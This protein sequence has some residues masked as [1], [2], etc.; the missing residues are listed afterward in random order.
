MG[1]SAHNPR[2]TVIVLA[3]ATTLALAGC[4]GGD[5]SEPT[6]TVGTQET[7]CE[8]VAPAAPKRVNLR[9]TKTR[10]ESGRDI[11]ATVDTNCGS[12]L[13]NLDTRTS[14][15]TVSSFVHLVEEGVYDGT[16]FHRVV[17][18]FLVQGGDP[19]AEGDGDPGYTIIERPPPNT[20]Y[21]QRTVAMAKSPV[22]PDGASGSQFFVV[23]AIDAGLSPQYALLGKVTE[24]YAAV[25]RMEALAPAD[26]A[27]GE[28][29]TIPVVISDVTL[30]R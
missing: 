23:T 11:A 25:E 2:A 3:L 19:T 12:F 26:P 20:A 17:P 21:T 13:I 10:I 30:D 6:T 18:S 1:A 22:E 29:P 14:P 24:G 28:E 16:A 7:D 5:D 9:P 27:A 4:G 8:E 15:K